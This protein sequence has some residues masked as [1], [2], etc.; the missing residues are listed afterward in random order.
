MIQ[1]YPIGFQD[2]SEIRTGG[3][4]YVDKTPF[5]EALVKANSTFFLVHADLV[6]LRL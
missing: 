1:K 5:I 3:Y 6:S 4:V 2:F